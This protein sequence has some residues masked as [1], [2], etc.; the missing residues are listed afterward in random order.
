MAGRPLFEIAEQTKRVVARFRDMKQGE[1]ITWRE[2]SH[3]IGCNSQ[4]EGRH[5]VKT[6]RDV[7]LREGKVFGCVMGE[8]VKWYTDHDTAKLPEWYRR[9]I[10]NAARKQQ[11]Q[12]NTIN[13]ARLTPRERL[14]VAAAQANAGTLALFASRKHYEESTKQVANHL[15]PPPP[16]FQRR[17][18]EAG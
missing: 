1:L 17:E 16:P 12:L 6:A 5:F 11:K 3:I 10:Y 2:L 4:E 18:G 7:M 13:L 8:G 9:R 15:P 14:E